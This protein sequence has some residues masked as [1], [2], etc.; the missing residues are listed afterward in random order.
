MDERSTATRGRAE[1]VPAATPPPGARQAGGG[2]GAAAWRLLASTELAIWLLFAISLTLAVGSQCAKREPAVAELNFLRF[3]EWLA[4]R[5]ATASWWLWVLFALL[6]AF[7]LNTAVCT[8]ERLAFLLRRRKEFRSRAF[9]VSI[10]PSVMHL[11]F[12]VIV[13]GHAVSQFTATIRR[14]P[15]AEGARLAL[16]PGVLEVKRSGCTRRPEPGLTHL[17]QGCSASLV[18]SSAGR[19]EERTVAILHPIRWQGYSVH[20]KPRGLAKPGERA[21]L[22]LVVKKDAGLALILAGNVALSLLMLWY[23]PIVIRKRNGDRACTRA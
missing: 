11:L 18:L 6:L 4:V 2:L 12:L 15:A 14:M 1:E 8:T 16:P 5:G 3:Q 10:A 20:L 21:A 23:F 7:G 9:A 19:E 22:E 17:V 13:S